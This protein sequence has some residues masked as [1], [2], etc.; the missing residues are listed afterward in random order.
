MALNFSTMY[1]K[2]MSI[3]KHKFSK[4]L[5]KSISFKF[6]SKFS[7]REYKYESD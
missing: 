2:V 3:I 1:D 6:H 4:R 5:V 7:S